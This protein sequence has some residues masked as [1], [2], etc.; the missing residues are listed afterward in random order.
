MGSIKNILAG[1]VP[2]SHEHAKSVLEP[3]RVLRQ[4]RAGERAAIKKAPLVN[5]VGPTAHLH[6]ALNLGRVDRCDDEIR[7]TICGECNIFASGHKQW[8]VYR[9]GTAAHVQGAFG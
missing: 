1:I 6:P 7:P 4:F 5:T 9:G 8:S 3:S 2:V